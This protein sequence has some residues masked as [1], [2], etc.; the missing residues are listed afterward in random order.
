MQIGVVVVGVDRSIN[1]FKLSYAHLCLTEIKNCLFVS[2]NT[3]ATYPAGNG[4]LF[5]GNY[6]NSLYL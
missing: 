5:P 3:D 1:Y 6:F 4:R 2:T